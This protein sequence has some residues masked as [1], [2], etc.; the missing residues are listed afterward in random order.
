MKID[1][2][3]N[4]LIP[5]FIKRKIAGRE[6]LKKIVANISWL[7]ADKILRMGMGLIVG[8]WTARYLG[9]GQYGIL[10]Y[11]IAFVSLFLPFTTLGLDNIV[12]REIVRD[13][14]RREEILGTSFFLKLV[15]G[16]VT[17]ALV[18]GLIAVVRDR[19]PLTRLLVGISAA[20]MIFQS[21]DVID[22]WFQSQVT[23]KFSVFAKNA[24]FIII[25]LTK[26]ILIL[27]KAP[28]V[29]FAL[30]GLF[31]IIIGSVFLIIVYRTRG[32]RLSAWKVNLLRGKDLLKESWPL[33]LSGLAIMIYLRIDQ[34]MLGNI[35]GDSAVGSYSA[36][37]KISEIWYF[38]PTAIVGTV[39][40][41]IIEAK[42]IS[43]KLYHDRLQKLFTLMSI[44]AYSIAI[45][46]TFLSNK[47]VSVLFGPSYREAGPILAISVWA[48]LFVS[49]G[50]ARGPW[51][52]A[53]NLTKFSFV[54][55]AFGA[56]TN[57]LLNIYLIPLY[58]GIGAA[59]ATVVSYAIG[60]C[61]GNLIYRR[62]REIFYI[63]LRAVFLTNMN[64][65]FKDNYRDTNI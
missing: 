32:H 50:V 5:D 35:I 61:L 59:I 22:F 56:I 25:A 27:L 10:N 34:V 37:I 1:Q 4:V 39:F 33:I 17:L 29:A 19:D 41:S 12:I 52:I 16:I 62:T 54:T 55:T 45:P 40:P 13:P 15:G 9:P 7:F 47:I 3:I 26:I 23:S 63:Q 57:V 6:S 2:T 51:I 49:V 65:L 28:L 64:G 8:A 14:V 31:E 18:L 58:G 46:M 43:D 24:A 36:A 44:L 38:V 30:A 20:G 21:F 60:S 48:G 53:E 11:A 42:K